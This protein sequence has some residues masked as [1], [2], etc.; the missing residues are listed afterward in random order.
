M[1]GQWA[2]R[3]IP[4]L[5]GDVIEIEFSEAPVREGYD[6]LRFEAEVAGV[7]MP[8]ELAGSVGSHACRYV[9]GL[10]A[11]S[12]DVR[13][14]PVWGQGGLDWGRYVSTVVEAGQWT[15]VRNVETS[16]SAEPA[17][18][19][20]KSR[21]TGI[22]PAGMV[23][24]A[25]G[26]GFDTT[27]PYHD[28]H[29][30]WSFSDPG[31]YSRLGSD[32]PWKNDR[33]IA[34]GPV[35][36]HTWDMPGTYTVNCIARHGGQAATVTFNVIIADPAAAFPAIRTICVSQ[37]GN[38]DGAPDGAMQVTSMLQAQSAKGRGAD[39]RILLRRGETF[40]ENLDIMHSAGN[41]QIGA[42]GEG[43]DPIWL[44][45]MGGGRGFTFRGITGEISI[46]GIDM[47]GPYDAGRPENTIKPNDAISIQDSGT[48]VT[49]H[50]MH[51]SGWSTTIRP[52]FTGASE[53]IVVSDT[54]ITNW[55]NYGYLGGGQQWIGF[56][57]TSIKQN[58]STYSEGGKFEDVSPFIPDHGPFR[59]GGAFKPHC[60]VSCDLAS[61]NSWIGGEHQP[62]I[63]WNSSGKDVAGQ[64]SVDRLRAEGG[65]FG[66]GTANS[67]TA[68]FPS[69][70]VVDKMHFV[71]TTQPDAML[72][73]SRGGVTM[74]NVIAVQGNSKNDGGHHVKRAFSVDLDERNKYDH[75]EFY[76]CSIGDLRTD[77]YIWD[78]TLTILETFREYPVDPVVE[79]NIVYA[80]IHTTPI[81]ADAPLDMTLHWIPL[82][83]GRRRLDE[84]GGLPQPEYASDPNATTFMIPQPDSPAYQGATT[85]KVAYDD[86]FGVVRGANPSRGAVEPA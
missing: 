13:V 23:F 60:F 17:I 66:F 7:V 45:N 29:Y 3:A 16:V 47:R 77:Q 42:F 82:Y 12:N 31:Q 37:N 6:L 53:S 11:T 38:F 64:F 65:G 84:N 71:P 4:G 1:E 27:R 58:P 76:N 24:S 20:E 15:P 18:R 59:V 35:A 39:T 41:Y 63:R 57:G 52:I 22:A 30:T 33:D 73:T 44:E 32:F 61:F 50:D 70:V 25:L 85:G 72:G 21:D 74:R 14:R 10:K 68:S 78:D 86:F 75:V 79:N 55:H 51:M 2:A 40:Q 19:L 80:P 46:W 34:Y 9:R 56:S 36:T 69:Q 49:I 81:T 48:Y 62:C 8:L 5:S 67:S 54:Y 83:E 26:L 43:S 28:V